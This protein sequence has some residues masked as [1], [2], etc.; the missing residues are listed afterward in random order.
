MTSRRR[1]AAG[2]AAALTTAA[3]ILALAVITTALTTGPRTAAVLAVLLIGIPTAGTV[4]LVALCL[5]VDR[6]LSIRG[7]RR[8]RH[9]TAQRPARV[10]LHYITWPRPALILTDTPH[11]DCPHCH[12]AGGWDEPYADGAGEYGGTTAVQCDC[13]TDW[14]RTLLAAPGWLA[15]LIDPPTHDPW[16]STGRAAGGCSDEPPF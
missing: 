9:T 5:A 6:A 8:A 13:W 1:T 12:G 14:T 11:P 16:R 4:L 2:P 7:A 10:R 3:A 15:R